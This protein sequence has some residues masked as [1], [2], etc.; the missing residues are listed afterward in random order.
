MRRR[1]LYF[2]II[3][4]IASIVLLSIPTGYENR[5]LTQNILYDKAKVL[6][7]DN[8]DLSEISVVRLGT[9]QLMLR[10][11]SGPF[12]GDTIA[13][14]NPLLGDKRR[15]KIF[16][17]GDRVLSIS[18][19][20][21]SHSHIIESRAEEYY[22]QDLEI[23]LC[24]IFVIAL[25]LFAGAT[26]AKAAL[27]FLF[28]AL[29]FWKLLLPSL[30]SGYSPLF[31][32]IGVVVLTTSVIILLVAGLSRRGLVALLGAILGVV[33]TA[34]LA[35]IFG[36]YFKIPGTI[37]EYSDA[38]IYSGFAHLNFSEMFLSCIFIS[39]AGAVMDVAMDIAAAQDELNN[40]APHLSRKELIRSGLNVAS[41]VV[42]SMTTTLLFAYSGS[43]MFVFMAFMAQGVPMES[44]VNR[45]FIAAE[46]L[47]TMVG[48]FGLVLVAP[49]TALLGGYIF[50][51]V[52][53]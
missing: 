11:L 21:N 48:S 8:S 40:Q 9:Q 1:G 41:P 4:A 46:I 42:G 5:E 20:D 17:V 25:T 19:V 28:T 10:V 18:R 7:V 47:H 45:G 13:A 12:K 53:E 16:E 29:A 2:T 27:S 31:V 33:L 26:G 36:H 37:Q 44:I 52:V 32:S 35:L 15:D 22:R 38:L 39:S 49:V 50:K 34:T 6:E 24:V 30:L 3:V 43:F 23:V 14:N 51:R